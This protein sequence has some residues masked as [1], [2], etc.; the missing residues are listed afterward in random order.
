MNDAATARKALQQ[1][2]AADLEARVRRLLGPFDGSGR[3][4]DVGCG[5]GALAYALAP[6]MEEVIGV[7]AVE[8]LLAAAR[9]GGPP[10]CSFL[11]ADAA[12][13]PFGYGEFDLAGSL[14]LLHHVRRPELVVSEL[15]RVT[16]PGG[17]ILL[18]ERRKIMS[19]MHSPHSVLSGIMTIS[20]SFSVHSPLKSVI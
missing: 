4:L 7:D 1:E 6:H 11:V 19:S 20:N 13:L 2:R 16:R 8:E 5:T 15:A 12:K 18:S 14:R 9:D 10:N 17:R 3:A